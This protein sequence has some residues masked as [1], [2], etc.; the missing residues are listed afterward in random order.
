[1]KATF[2]PVVQ[3]DLPTTE[4]VSIAESKN[5]GIK[6][7]KDGDK[8]NVTSQ[9]QNCANLTKDIEDNT[10]N[11]EENDVCPHTAQANNNTIA[12]I[13]K[14]DNGTALIL[15]P[16]IEENLLEE[17][18]NASTVD[19]EVFLGVK[20]Y[21]GFITVN[22]TYGS[23]IFFWYF[24]VNDAT[25]PVNE[26]PWIIWMQGGPG[27]SSMTGLFDEI[28]PFRVDNSGK[29]VRKYIHF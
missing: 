23:N 14:V 27:A 5:E 29:L 22:E 25:K 9:A 20:S 16:L 17:A 4:T 3:I 12:D 21:S 7:E 19:P 2:E 18:R 10:I 8:V 24:P 1:M 11:S 28:G 13:P 15:T 6:P 26:T